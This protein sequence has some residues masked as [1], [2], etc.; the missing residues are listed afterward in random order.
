MP[1]VRSSRDYE[2]KIGRMDLQPFE[3]QT[4]SDQNLNP[5]RIRECTTLIFE[6]QGLAMAQVVHVL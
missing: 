4:T 1:P 3:L 5:E 2:V 6:E